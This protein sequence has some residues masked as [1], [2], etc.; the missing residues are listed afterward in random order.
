MI[1]QLLKEIKKALAH[2]ISRR[3]MQNTERLYFIHFR[4]YNEFLHS[5][6]LVIHYYQIS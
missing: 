3:I 6:C 4:S 2:N 1:L 5:G